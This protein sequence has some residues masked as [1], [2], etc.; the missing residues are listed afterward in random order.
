MHE[1]LTGYS[2]FVIMLLCFQ[3]AQRHIEAHDPNGPGKTY[4]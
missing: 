4:T 3:A 2:T 1:T